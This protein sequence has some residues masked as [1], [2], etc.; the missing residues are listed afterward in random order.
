MGQWR[1]SVAA[2]ET[3]IWA[4]AAGVGTSPGKRREIGGTRAGLALLLGGGAGAERMCVWCG[5]KTRRGSSLL[6]ELRICASGR[7][8]DVADG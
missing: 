4:G 1:G 8:A 6:G 2:G 5:R 7:A 3:P